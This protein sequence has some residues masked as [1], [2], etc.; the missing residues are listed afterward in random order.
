MPLGSNGGD[1]YN[2]LPFTSQE[3]PRAKKIAH[4]RPSNSA[5]RVT[6]LVVIGVRHRAPA[7]ASAAI[8][9]SGLFTEIW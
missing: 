6:R 2:K 9:V 8:H 5:P 3:T 4:L 7:P 1:L